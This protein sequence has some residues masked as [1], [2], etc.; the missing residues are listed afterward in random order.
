MEA[1]SRRGAH[2]PL[3]IAE[4]MDPNRG[5]KAKLIRSPERVMGVADALGKSAKI[6]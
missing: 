3:R 4:K 6:R 5:F 2:V 1:N